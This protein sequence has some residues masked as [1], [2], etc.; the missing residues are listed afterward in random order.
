MKAALR[1][2][3]F[4]GLAG[5]R[6]T[7]F[8]LALIAVIT[9]FAMSFLTE[10]WTYLN[11]LMTGMLGVM[12]VLIFVV[13]RTH[14]SGMATKLAR[15]KNPRATFRLNDAMISV[16]ADSG[17][18]SYPWRTFVSIFETKDVW[19]LVTAPN[20]FITMPVH[21]VNAEVRAF[22]KSKIGPASA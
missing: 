2:F 15:M 10:S 4:R 7:I 12:V 17:M 6:S 21:N 14:W 9:F 22:V 19:L 13:Y 8:I 1:S 18:V 16:E 11:G 20:Q 3:I 5:R